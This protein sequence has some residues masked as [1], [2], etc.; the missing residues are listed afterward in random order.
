[1]AKVTFTLTN[2]SAIDLTSTT[3]NP[4]AAPVS[5]PRQG[6]F[7]LRNRWDCAKISNATLI[8]KGGIVQTTSTAAAVTTIR[9]FY[10]LK[11]PARTFVRDISIAAVHGKTAPTTQGYYSSSASSAGN[12]AN[13]IK[14][15]T[16]NFNAAAWKKSNKTSLATYVNGFGEIDLAAVGAS[17]TGGTIAG[18]KLAVINTSSNSKISVPTNAGTV[19]EKTMTNMANAATSFRF[20]MYFPHGGYVAMRSEP[21]ASDLSSNSATADT[22]LAKYS[23]KMTGVWDIQ[24]QCNYVPV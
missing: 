14:S 7:T 9:P 8:D 3:A 10:V 24:A 12:A 11:V 5:T 20:P 22:E 13:N 15:W 4:E 17:A 18:S 19:M 21:G 2:T 16:L 6:G 1:M 23:H